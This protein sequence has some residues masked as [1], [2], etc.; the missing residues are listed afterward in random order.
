MNTN[1]KIFYLFLLFTAVGLAQFTGPKIYSPADKYDFGTVDAGNIIKHSYVV[2]NNGDDVLK[3]LNVHTSCGCT[4]A[5]PDKRE[6]KP[7]ETANIMIEFNT[8]GREGKQVKQINVASNDTSK[9]L[10]TLMLTG[11]VNAKPVEEPK[12]TGPKIQFL[13][14]QKDFGSVTEGDILPYVFIFKNAGDAELEIT[15]VK[16]SCGCTAAI[17][18]ATKLKPG[19]EA[20]LKVEFDTKDRSGRISR[21]IQVTTNEKDVPTKV[22]TIFADI[23]KKDAH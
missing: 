6:L 19:E 7:G 18:S 4:A 22:L 23:K 21:T 20:E 12:V 1:R 3:I 10:L 17:P 16:T 5:E 9:P 2:V 15:D 8:N 11:N 13:T 14:M